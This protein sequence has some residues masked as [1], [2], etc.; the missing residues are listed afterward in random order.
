[1]AFTGAAEHHPA[2]H[3]DSPGGLTSGG[4][5]LVRS[6]DK[7]ARKVPSRLAAPSSTIT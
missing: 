2:H 1:M 6:T 5:Q 3:R 7:F 4:E